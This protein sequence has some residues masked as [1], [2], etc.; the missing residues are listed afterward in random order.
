M[1]RSTRSLVL[2]VCQFRHECDSLEH[3]TA[4]KRRLFYNKWAI[5][6][7]QFRYILYNFY[8]FFFERSRIAVIV[9]NVV[10]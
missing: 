2:R 9:Y 6:S 8:N 7:S 5:M 4:H 3:S 1:D 10:L